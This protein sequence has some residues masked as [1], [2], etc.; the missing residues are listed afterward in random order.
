MQRYKVSRKERFEKIDKPNASPITKDDYKILRINPNVK[1]GEDH[2]VHFDDHYY[3]VP[4]RLTRSRVD[5]WLLGKIIEVYHDGDRVASHAV[6]T[7]V[8]GYSTLDS[9]RPPNHLFV[10]KLKPLWVLSKAKDIG[11]Q[12][13][14]MIADMISD[15]ARHCEVAVR[16]GLGLIDLCRDFPASRV[17]K[18]VIKAMNFSRLQISDVKCLLEQGLDDDSDSG[19]LNNENPNTCAHEN[20]RGAD[21]YKN[22]SKQGE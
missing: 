20:I 5:V 21:H 6:S 9:H 7:E 18:A 8:G 2:H 16:K 10:R 22:I 3:S 13:H 19:A 14:K 12:T 15:D 4:W 17:E 11:P 1:V